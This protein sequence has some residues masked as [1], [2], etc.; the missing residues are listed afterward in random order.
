[1]TSSQVRPEVQA[2][3][4]Q[5]S[6]AGSHTDP[7]AQLQ[8]WADS[9]LSLD[10][11]R[12]TPVTRAQMLAALPQRRAMFARIG[13]TASELIDAREMPLDDRHIVVRTSWRWDLA[14]TPDAADPLVLH[15]TFLLRRETTGWIVVYLNHQDVAAAITERAPRV[16][17]SEIATYRTEMSVSK[18]S[19]DRR[20]GALAAG[21]IT[22]SLP[23]GTPAIR[24]CGLR[25][26]ARRRLVF[27]SAATRTKPT[28]V[29]A[30]S[31]WGA[32]LARS[33]RREASL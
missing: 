2:F 12:A 16:S 26:G 32:A 14:D 19:Q 33:G 20:V 21:R 15:S 23:L 17:G 4:Q 25:A 28:F 3:L 6:G 7:D 29:V 24:S 1:M 18:P 31:L 5:F 8:C 22:R 11:N 30:T 9:F 27:V 13:A 10:P